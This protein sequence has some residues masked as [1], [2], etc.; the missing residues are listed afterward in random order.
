MERVIAS[1]DPALH[2]IFGIGPLMVG[3][4]QILKKRQAPLIVALANL[5]LRPQEVYAPNGTIGKTLLAANWITTVSQALLEQ[6]ATYRPATRSHISV[7]YSGYPAPTIEIAPLATPPC[8]LLLGRL[9][10]QK[11]G[12]M[13]IAAFR[14]L[15]HRYPDA[16]LIIAGDGPLREPWQQLTGGMEDRVEFTGWISPGDVYAL[17]NRV[18]IVLMPSNWEGLPIVA[19]EAAFM[20]R[21][22]VATRIP[23]MS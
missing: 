2:H 6:T 8:L 19:I 10:S 15:Y 9:V 21:P 14:K 4:L 11:G 3:C 17:M 7:L 16:R 1:F 23:G 13:A 5:E 12:E 20:K 18:T 22:M